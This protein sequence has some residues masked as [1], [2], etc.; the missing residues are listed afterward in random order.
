MADPSGL[1]IEYPIVSNFREGLNMLE[2]VS[3]THGARKGLADTALRTAK[4]G[5]LTRRLVDVAQ[6][7]IITEE[8][9][10]TDKGIAIRPLVRD[11]KVI[12]PL[13]ERIAGRTA[14]VDIINPSTGE[15]VVKSGEIIDNDAAERIEKLGIE[16]VM[17]RSPMTCALQ[18]GICRACY[19][20]DL[21]QR[22]KV[23]IGEAVGVV[24][25]QSIGEPGTQLTMRTFHT[26]GVRI[27]GE[28]ITQGLP[29]IEQL[30]EVRKPKKI[31]Y[32]ADM[33]G[34][35]SEIREMEGK[36]KVFITSEQGEVEYKSSFTIPASQNLLVEEGQKVKKGQA[37]TEGYVDP[38]QLLEIEGIE[39]VQN[40]L[41][42]NI[43]D[44]YR[45][46][47]VS[48]NNKHIEVILRKVAPVNRVRIVDEGDSSFVANDL[49]WVKDL[50]KEIEE[51]RSENNKF[52][53]E[54]VDAIEGKVFREARGQ[55]NLERVMAFRDE[56]LDENKIR[57]ILMPG[58]PVNE[59]LLEDEKGA[60]RIIVGEASFRR[61][62]EGLE[63]VEPALLEEGK[64]IEANVPLSAGQ[65][66]LLTKGKPVEYLVRDVELLEELEDK[67]YL[68]DDLI[69]D[70]EVVAFKDRVVTGDVIKIVREQNIK[71]LKVWKNPEAVTVADAMQKKLIDELWGKSLTKAVDEEGNEVKDIAHMVDGRVVRG[72]IAKELT[73]IEVEGHIYTRQSILRQA[74]TEVAYG[75]VLLED[76]V[77]L[78]GNLV[79]F[80]G[81]DVNH[82]VLDSLVEADPDV[83]VVRHIYAQSET[84]SVIQRVS[85]VRR[86]RNEPVWK[87]VIHGITKAAL[88]TDSFLSAASFQQTAQVLAGAAVRG[89]HD[90]LKGL[91]ENVIIG[92]LIPA[93]TGRDEYRKIQV[94][95]KRDEP[96][97]EES[98]GTEG[99]EDIFE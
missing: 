79:A 35:V 16:E 28:D 30:F 71:E 96:E 40:Y 74:L 25:A 84:K 39:S 69:L 80:A 31:A 87:P 37:M 43:Q 92:H 95:V 93:G 22:K 19:G 41:V 72:L 62:M 81:M 2:Y 60:L 94:T 73:A 64:K 76:V 36:R 1:I 75:K 55:G 21:S 68:A 54:A 38:Y 77:D 15:V 49:V 56:V 42:D 86:L 7:L 63:L 10:G 9:C 61:E 82:Q 90:N 5:Y 85:F 97:S 65:L 78:K 24:A 20:T 46:Q 53:E 27:T 14:L 91:K 4:S 34:V 6:D 32:L 70:G 58:T 33:D 98:K 83:L 29:R 47:G 52:I 57:R 11:G 66:L 8:D 45:S 12:I 18:N 59:L 67:A 88:N 99:L 51:I 13:H 89:D 3:S 50:E 17:V 48:I 23:A 44:V 26:G